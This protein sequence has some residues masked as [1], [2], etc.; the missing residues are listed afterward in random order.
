MDSYDDLKTEIA[1]WL[2]RSDLSARVD[3]FIDIAEA[4]HAREIRI[5]EMLSSDTLTLSEDST[6]ISLPDDFLDFYALRVKVPDATSGRKY[7]PGVEEVTLAELSSRAILDNRRPCGFT[8]HETI[9]FSA[10]ADQDYEVEFFYY[11]MLPALADDQQTNALL[12]K[13]GDVYL[14][15]ALSASAPFLLNDERVPVW[16]SLYVAARDGLNRSSRE[17]RRGGPLV[18]RVHGATP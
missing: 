16:E 17:S 2:D 4:R 6:T 1:D 14:Y 11:S 15:A 5:R 3:T 13:A 7:L 10:P 18:S 8:V 9:E 12:T